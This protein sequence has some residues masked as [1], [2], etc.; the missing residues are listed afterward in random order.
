MRRERRH[1]RTGSSPRSASLGAMASPLA[2][3]VGTLL[4]K[5]VLRFWKVS[6]QTWPRRC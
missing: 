6:F 3:P 1:E 4:Y 2:A 5:E